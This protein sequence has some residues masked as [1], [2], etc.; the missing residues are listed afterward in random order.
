MSVRPLVG[1]TVK[2]T[3]PNMK[4]CMK[5]QLF[6]MIIRIIMILVP[7]NHDDSANMKAQMIVC[8]INMMH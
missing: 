1:H 6:I 4:I 7:G 2:T 5:L 3:F 8:I